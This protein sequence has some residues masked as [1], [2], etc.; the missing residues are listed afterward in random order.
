MPCSKYSECNYV[1]KI[2]IFVLYLELIVKLYQRC[3]KSAIRKEKDTKTHF[4]GALLAVV[5]GNV[6]Q[7]CL[8]ENSQ[9]INPILRL[10]LKSKN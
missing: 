7:K 3:P 1:P 2:H 5:F 6:F 10:K 4:K 9:R 8:E